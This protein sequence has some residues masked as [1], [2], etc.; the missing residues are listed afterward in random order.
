MNKS[1]LLLCFLICLSQ[2]FSSCSIIS[3]NW[4]H[5]TQTLSEFYGTHKALLDPQL[6][7]EEKLAY[8]HKNGIKQDSLRQCSIEYDGL[9]NGEGEDFIE[10]P[11]FD[12]SV[13]K[14]ILGVT[15]NYP[16]IVKKMI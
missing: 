16:V 8:C 13:Y 9:I 3:E 15:F 11:V 6:S 2:L 7:E 10:L 4:P 5:S 12:P 14:N 1:K